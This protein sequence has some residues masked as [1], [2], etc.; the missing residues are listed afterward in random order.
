MYTEVETISSEQEQV[1]R[2]GPGS[3]SCNTLL[4][5][6]CPSAWPPRDQLDPQM[7]EPLQKS[8]NPVEQFHQTH[9]GTFTCDWQ[10]GFQK[11]VHPP[12]WCSPTSFLTQFQEN[13][14]ILF[15]TGTV[16]IIELQ[17]YSF[18]VTETL[19]PLTNISLFPPS[20]NPGNHQSILC[21]CEFVTDPKWYSRQAI[22]LFFFCLIA[23]TRINTDGNSIEQKW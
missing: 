16:V 2:L 20:S 6:F 12:S 21:F 15:T 9:I 3:R 5:G 22:I 13:N 18:L 4:T 19:Y 1:Y 14:Q 17:E 7:R 23:L 10:Q 8:R 11:F